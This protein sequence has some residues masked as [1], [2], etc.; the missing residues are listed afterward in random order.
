MPEIHSASASIDA[1]IEALSSPSSAMNFIQDMFSSSLNNSNA[2]NSNATPNPPVTLDSLLQ[3]ARA[4]PDQ[5]EL[6]TLFQY[7]MDQFA[8]LSSGNQTGSF[9]FASSSI[10]SFLERLNMLN[11]GTVNQT[12]AF[13]QLFSLFV[14]NFTFQDLLRMF[15][16]NFH[17]YDRLQA[18]L[19]DF[20]RQSVLGGSDYTSEGLVNLFDE[21]IAVHR[22]QIA[23]IIVSSLLVAMV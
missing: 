10:G 22:D 2:S 7:F 8:S 3:Q 11:P 21:Y 13:T 17:G 19:L 5:S 18:P 23:S 14:Q 6:V 1:T 12:N 15:Q 16:P 9:D 20:V 4:L